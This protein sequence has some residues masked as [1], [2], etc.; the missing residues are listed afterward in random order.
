MSAAFLLSLQEKYGLE[1]A[2]L[3]TREVCYRIIKPATQEQQCAFVDLLH[4]SDDVGKATVFVSH[5]WDSN[6]N[7]IISAM[8]EYSRTHNINGNGNSDSHSISNSDSNSSNSVQCHYFWFDVLSANQHKKEDTPFEW[9][10]STFRDNIASIGRVLLIMTPWN[11]PLPITRSWCLWEIFSAIELSQRGVE[12]SVNLPA[13]Q[14]HVFLHDVTSS[15][16]SVVNALIV[17]DA[18]DATTSRPSDRENIFKA[19]NAVEGGI[20]A[21]NRA[22]KNRLR[23]W[24]LNTAIDLA[25]IQVAGIVVGRMN[26]NDGNSMAADPRSLLNLAKMISEFGELDKAMSYFNHCLTALTEDTD[27][28]LDNS[29]IIHQTILA[30]VY[31]CIGIT[32]SKQSRYDQALEYL[33]KAIELSENAKFLSLDATYSGIGV[34]L[35]NQGHPEKALEYLNKALAISKS[36]DTLNNIGA[37]HL[38]LGDHRKALEYFKKALVKNESDYGKNHPQVAISLINVGG[39]HLELFHYDDALDCFSKALGIHRATFG[40]NHAMVATTYNNMVGI[41]IA[42]EQFAEALEYAKKALEIRKSVFGNDHVET[43]STYDNIGGCYAH[44]GKHVQAQESFKYALDIRRKLLGE[45]HPKTALSYNHV[46]S[47]YF[48]QG[49]YDMAKQNYEKTLALRLEI[50]G[51]DSPL[52]AASYDDLGQACD[53]LTDFD[54]AIYNF[55]K[56][57]NIYHRLYG[58]TYPST[59]ISNSNLEEAKL[60]KSGG[61]AELDLLKQAVDDMDPNEVF[62]LLRSAGALPAGV[63]AVSEQDCNMQ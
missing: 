34:V 24:Y 18:R 22:V 30:E 61:G 13:A 57:K 32:Y 12:L 21:L 29:R 8:V 63:G 19:I 49:Q 48:Q 58:E 11:A 59:I 55:T 1:S 39:A 31:D 43:A 52:T 44:Q 26:K 27:K 5:A 17:M 9:W 25:D 45:K 7:E 6:V 36:S 16:K 41:L 62:N 37:V 40:E 15:H 56:A 60:K 4:G 54:D 33:Y 46:A 51:E 47:S 53:K 14:R 38:H 35:L 20:D 50:Y 10:C 28:F 42:Q 3:T 2:E 23:G